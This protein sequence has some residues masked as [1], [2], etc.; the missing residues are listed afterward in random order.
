MIHDWFLQSQRT[1]KCYN[2]VEQ[3]SGGKKIKK[4]ATEVWW[5]MWN[6]SVAVAV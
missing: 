1:A 2:L 6:S 4:D 3:E 5:W